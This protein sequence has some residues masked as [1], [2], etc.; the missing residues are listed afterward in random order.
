MPECYEMSR[1]SLSPVLEDLAI[2]VMKAC[3]QKGEDAIREAGG[4]IVAQARLFDVFRGAQAG[5]GKRPA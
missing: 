5:E 1:C 3:Q 2:V 4:S